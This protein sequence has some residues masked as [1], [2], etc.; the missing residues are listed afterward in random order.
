[1]TKLFGVS[2]K[3]GQITKKQLC[4]FSLNKARANPC[5]QPNC[6]FHYKAPAL[7]GFAPCV[8]LFGAVL[9]LSIK[10][11]FSSNHDSLS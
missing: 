8:V 4:G 1:M 5:L 6:L 2:A 3:L 7:F 10:N 11:E 9:T